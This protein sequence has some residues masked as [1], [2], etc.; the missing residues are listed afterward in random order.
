DADALEVAKQVE[1]TM[2]ELSKSFPEGLTYSIPYATTP[3][4]TESIKEVLLTLFSAFLLVMLVVYV[5]LQSPR[6]TLIPMV[7]VPVS[8]IGTMAAYSSLGF[9]IN[10]LTLFGLLLSIGIVVD[11]AIVVVE[12][13]QHKIDD[14]GMT[15]REAAK[16][17]MAEVGGP[18]IAIAMV[19]CAVFIPV[20]FVG[21]L[22]GELY[23][24][25]ALTIAVSVLIS[26]ICALTLSP[27][28]CALLLKPKGTVHSFA[29]TAFF[30]RHFNRFFDWFR[31]KYSKSVATLIRRSA[32]VALT[33]LI[34]LGALYF[35]IS[36]RPSGLVPQEDQG[37]LIAVISLPPAAS[38]G[39]TAQALAQFENITKQVP[40]VE[41]LIAINGFNLLTGL[42]TSYNATSFIRLKPWGQ[43]KGP[44][45]GSQ[46]IQGALMGMLNM[47]IKDASVL[48]ISP[49]AI[50]GLGQSSGFDLVLQDK[51]GGS[52]EQ[53]AQV[54]NQF[55]GSLYQK[56]EI[57][58][59]FSSFN[60]GVP[61]I[62]YAVDREKVKSLG[63]SLS[64]VYFTLQTFLG[65]YYV[66]DF[67]L[68]GRTFK[69]TAQADSLMRAHPEDID[70]YYVKNSGGAMV[71][72]S[73]VLK[74]KRFNGPEYLERYNLY[75]A[76]T[77]TGSAKPGVSSGQAV[78]AVEA[79][80]KALPAG[81]T[82]DWTG[83]TFQ[84]KKTAGQTGYIFAL[85]LVFVF[86]VLAALYESWAMPV[87]ILLVIPFGVL[88]AFTGLLLRNIEN[89]VY[90]QI[91]L[92]MLI[93][94]AAKNAILIVEFAKISREKGMS[95]FQA[96]IA[97]SQL[98]LRAIL[99]TSFSFIFGTMPLALATGAGAGARRSLGTA[100]V[101]GMLFAT[102]IGIF[103]IP[104]FYAV[105]QRI[106]E[107]KWPFKN[108]DEAGGGTAE[109]HADDEVKS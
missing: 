93:G 91:G 20:A 69:V 92:V 97:G 58:F 12:A 33:F 96:A 46:A 34:M 52:T 45:Q 35:L 84:E 9:T 3:F 4:V 103:V 7:V 57:G 109:S 50:S 80:A 42:T 81:Y 24:Q 71:P 37:Y 49:P 41:G 16:A 43:R 99:M 18:V 2:K 94:L 64:D 32:L 40:G 74:I 10:T 75:R 82:I 19:L 72:L 65:G 30:F 22:T 47:G 11:D 51:S 68:Y 77:I 39:R 53:F 15:A 85:C 89:N 61:Q 90:V 95:I 17:A 14:M 78:A 106:S 70:K 60:T 59:A 13:I 86:L 73:T 66:N 67:N 31:T 107:K 83:A 100:V 27:A 38:S 76:V 104:V 88:G 62:E 26:A 108:E 55:V 101:F 63:L 25:F 8:L 6:A 44:G 48:I 102:M 54:M 98:R 105:I 23:K 29:V 36:T 21:G 79:A 5:F 56:P 28:L 87:S 1:A